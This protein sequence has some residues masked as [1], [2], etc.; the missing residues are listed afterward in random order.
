MLWEIKEKIIWFCNNKEKIPQMGKEAR[1]LAEKYKWENYNL[2]LKEEIK[3][4]K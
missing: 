1:I 3:K 4:I 2:N